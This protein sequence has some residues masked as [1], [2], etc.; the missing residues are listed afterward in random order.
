MLPVDAEEPP[1]C[2]EEHGDKDRH[3]LGRNQP[4][5][6]RHLR[7]PLPGDRTC[8]LTPGH[9]RTTAGERQ[10]DAWRMKMIRCR[11]RGGTVCLLRKEGSPDASLRRAHVCCRWSAQRPAHGR[12]TWLRLCPAFYQE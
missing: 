6:E 12:G 7:L 2:P 1:H 4:L 5:E 9:D 3:C 8:A 11:D 10:Q